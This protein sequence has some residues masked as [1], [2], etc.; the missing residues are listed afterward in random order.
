[1]RQVPA[2]LA[3]LTTLKMPKQIKVRL[4]RKPIDTYLSRVEDYAF[5]VT[6]L[7][8]VSFFVMLNQIKL[9]QENNTLAESFSLLSI[10]LN[11]VWSFFLFYYHFLLCFSYQERL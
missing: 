5:L 6:M 2:D 8:M 1:M 3:Y 10:V 4:E 7:V 11:L 9:V